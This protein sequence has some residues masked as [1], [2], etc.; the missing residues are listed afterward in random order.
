MANTNT[1]APATTAAAEAGWDRAL[2]FSADFTARR[3]AAVTEMQERLAEQRVARAEAVGLAGIERGAH[4]TYTDADG[5][6]RTGTFSRVVGYGRG[7][8][9]DY[10]MVEVNT[11]GAEAVHVM[12]ERVQRAAAPALPECADFTGTGQR[13][14]TCRVHRRNHA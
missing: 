10:L 4:L 11:P 5:R 7:S 6:T 14:G 9:V 12:P 13:C 3:E 1:P 8:R 2:G